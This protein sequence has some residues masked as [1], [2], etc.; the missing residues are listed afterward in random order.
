MSDSNEEVLKAG[1]AVFAS[2]FRD[3]QRTLTTAA[4]DNISLVDFSIV[5]KSPLANHQSIQRWTAPSE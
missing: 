4:V 1:D 2:E 5:L 3:F